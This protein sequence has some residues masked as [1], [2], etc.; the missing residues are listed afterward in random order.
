MYS[1]LA[2]FVIALA[3]VLSLTPL[4]RGLAIEWGVVDSPGGRRVHQ[5]AIPRLGGV[6]VVGAFYV[7][8][9]AVFVADTDVA[10]RFFADSVRALG[11]VVGGLLMCAVG[12]LDD[13]RG[14]RAIHKLIA[15]VLV[16]GIA[17]A[18]GFRIEAI[19][20]PLLPTVELGFLAPFATT[21]WIVAV[22]NAIN[23]IDGLDGLA[24]GVA[25]FACATNFVIASM[26]G[27]PL[28]M[29]LSAALG[30]AVFG[31]LFFNFNPA[32]IFM[33]DSGSLFIGYVLATMS[34]LGASI[35]SSTAVSILV[36]LIALGLP[37]I[38]TL[39]AIVRRILRRQSI[40]AADRS[41]IHH[42]L[43]SLGLTHRRA[44]ITLYSVC[45][46][47]TTGAIVVSIE[48]NRDA[49]IALLVLSMVAIGVVAVASVFNQSLQRWRQREM[50]WG[51]AVDGMRRLV[52]EALVRLQGAHEVQEVGRVLQGFV[53]QEPLR[54]VELLHCALPQL[55]SLTCVGARRE[56]S[57]KGHQVSVSFAL[58]AAG[59]DAALQFLWINE[60]A[61]LSREANVLLQLVVDACDAALVRA[62][63]A[64]EPAS[65]S[66]TNGEALVQTAAKS[67][68]TRPARSPGPL[69]ASF[70]SA[71]K[72]AT[73]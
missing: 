4:V 47:L 68:S 5:R 39:L 17:Y 28:V 24:G 27:D 42:L 31:F 72:P 19:Y 9:L 41:H 43:L 63:I 25:F 12:V 64:P 1:S 18:A 7:A 61:A 60:E 67:Q 3:G 22:I 14:V 62:G 37:I 45:V 51:P 26:S 73:K 40:F 21:L 2:V 35:K 20:L 23:L 33:G 13:V 32:S 16:A 8:L 38:D 36:P 6:A 65:A 69:A 71:P 30:G 53:G 29:L 48:R 44:V 57:A 56:T 58:P 15:Q 46:F 50:G 10:Q 70:S 49:G 59:E 54:S 34:I 11:L 55:A 52:P 66:E